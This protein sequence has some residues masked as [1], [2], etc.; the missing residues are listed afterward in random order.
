MERHKTGQ[1]M[2]KRSKVLQKQTIERVHG[3]T[4]SE[5]LFFCQPIIISSEARPCT[6][7][8]KIAE[9][10]DKSFQTTRLSDFDE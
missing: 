10:P 7:P 2:V 9:L 3:K 6:P 1:A 8:K 4:V 5:G